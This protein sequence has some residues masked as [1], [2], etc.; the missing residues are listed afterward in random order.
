MI[1]W[2]VVSVV[3]VGCSL[4]DVGRGLHRWGEPRDGWPEWGGRYVGD[5]QSS[6]CRSK[7]SV[8]LR[9]PD[10]APSGTTSRCSVA[11]R[12]PASRAAS[13]KSRTL[14]GSFTPGDD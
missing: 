7:R 12:R 5:G 4:F 11:T 3:M 2:E 1:G 6:A 13:T 9:G 10:N 8:A 14:P